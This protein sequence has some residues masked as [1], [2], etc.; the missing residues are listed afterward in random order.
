MLNL[1]Y[2]FNPITKMKGTAAQHLQLSWPQETDRRNAMACSCPYR[3]L[4]SGQGVYMRKLEKGSG[5]SCSAGGTA[6]S[7]ST[8]AHNH[9]ILTICPIGQAP[10]PLSG[11]EPADR[12]SH[13]HLM[14]DVASVLCKMG[15]RPE[16]P[17]LFRP[18]LPDLA[19]ISF[20]ASG[21][22]LAVGC[23]LTPPNDHTIASSK[24]QHLDDECRQPSP[25]LVHG[26]QF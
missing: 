4:L 1:E 16:G 20:I 10:S 9:P 22:P 13:T 15:N 6:Q 14:Q 3:I 18:P 24:K 21:D 23:A 12:C 7:I 26:Q 11:Q 5:R 25:Y 19:D 8:S 17:E 2:T